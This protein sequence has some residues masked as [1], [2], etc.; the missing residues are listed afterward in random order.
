M[1]YYEITN[2]DCNIIYN[3]LEQLKKQR[4][5]NYKKKIWA[6]YFMYI[7]EI[8]INEINNNNQ[9]FIEEQINDIVNIIIKLLSLV[10]CIKP[11][12][13]KMNDT[14]NIYTLIDNSIRCFVNNKEY[15]NSSYYLMFIL[16]NLGYNP[17]KCI[18]EKMKSKLSK[19][20]KINKRNY[21][22]IDNGVY[23]RFEL[24]DILENEYILYDNINEL[25]NEYIIT[26]K[27]KEV[28]RYNKWYKANYGICKL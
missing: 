3:Y 21:Y 20:G 25:E 26:F 18:S 11:I 7:S 16:V 9:D 5:I 8:D 24:I 23:N 2:D 6:I 4:N 12:K 28:G 13:I 15:L 10:D 14:K 27:G 22:I 19:K 1:K 17:I